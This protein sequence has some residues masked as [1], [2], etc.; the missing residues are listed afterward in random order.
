MEVA[1]TGV[2]A[3][4]MMAWQACG[5]DERG[6]RR[7]GAAEGAAWRGGTAGGGAWGRC[8]A[9]LLALCFASC[10]REGCCAWLSV[11]RERK[12]TG[13]REEEKKKKRRKRKEKK[14]KN[15]IFF[16]KLGNF[17]KNKR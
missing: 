6:G 2:E 14:E 15:M 13:G 9:A 1:M 7:R 16:F 11:V 5:R 12:E 8:R 17:P 10:S 4:L 3:P